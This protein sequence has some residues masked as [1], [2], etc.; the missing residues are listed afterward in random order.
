[1]M[2]SMNIHLLIDVLLIYIA[3]KLEQ[4]EKYKK[5]IITASIQ[6][7]KLDINLEEFY[8]NKLIS[9][10]PLERPEAAYF[11]QCIKLDNIKEVLRL[12][13]INKFLVYE[14]DHVI[15]F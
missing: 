6:F 2:F 1:M 4:Y 15:L 9:S 10:K 3:K 8:S 13:N 5:C 7:R 14:F 12:L 11:F